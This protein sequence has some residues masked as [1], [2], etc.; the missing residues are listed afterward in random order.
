MTE[1]DLWAPSQDALG[2]LDSSEWQRLTGRYQA[3]DLEVVVGRL[4]M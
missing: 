1:A 4:R 3:E 2:L